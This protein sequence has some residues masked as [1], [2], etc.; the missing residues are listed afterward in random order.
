MWK[1]ESKMKQHHEYIDI[2]FTS[3]CGVT[4]NGKMWTPIHTSLKEFK[5]F[6]VLPC[7]SCRVERENYFTNALTNH[8]SSSIKFTVKLFMI[9]KVCGFLLRN[10][11][12]NKLQTKFNRNL[13]VRCIYTDL[14]CPYIHTDK[15][16]SIRKRAACEKWA[17]AYLQK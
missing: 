15:H 4:C 14:S 16:Q 8:D 5:T 12:W 11:R 10:L 13:A 9:Y 17:G 6:W 2:K 1:G 3:S 7:R